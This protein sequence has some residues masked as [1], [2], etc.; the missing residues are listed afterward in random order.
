MYIGISVVP[1]YLESKSE[2]CPSAIHY[3]PLLPT[4]SFALGVSVSL[5]DGFIPTIQVLEVK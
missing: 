3:L 4:I 5:Q 1:L 2:V